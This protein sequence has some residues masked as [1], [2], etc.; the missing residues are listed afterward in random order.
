MKTVL[1]KTLNL[2]IDI[3]FILKNKALLEKYT[4]SFEKKDGEAVTVLKCK[5]VPRKEVKVIK[6]GTTSKGS[7]FTMVDPAF[8]VVDTEKGEETIYLG[9]SNIVAF[10]GGSDS[11]SSDVEKLVAKAK[12]VDAQVADVVKPAGW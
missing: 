7:P 5:I 8:L 9:N 11:G 6:E 12:E 10:T 3:T 1:E 4:R 2:E